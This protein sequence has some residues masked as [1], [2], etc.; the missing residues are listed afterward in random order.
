MRSFSLDPV[1][2]SLAP[3]V[4]RRMRRSLPAVQPVKV[5]PAAV[6]VVPAET[7]ISSVS[8]KP[9][10]VIEVLAGSPAPPNWLELSCAVAS[11]LVLKVN[12]SNRSSTF[13]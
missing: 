13:R 5:K 11:P 1:M 3:A 9:L 12:P 4:S 2:F 6:K 10:P 7:K 8:L